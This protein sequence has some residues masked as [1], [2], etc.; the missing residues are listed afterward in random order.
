MQGTKGSQIITITDNDLSYF[1]FSSNTYSINE[2]QNAVITINRKSP[3]GTVDVAVKLAIAHVTTNIADVGSFTPTVNF[4]AGSI[5]QQFTVNIVDDIEDESDETFTIAISAVP[6]VYNI[7]PGGVGTTT[8]TIVDNDVNVSTAYINTT[9]MLDAPKD[10]LEHRNHFS[11]CTFLL[12]KMTA[13]L[14]IIK[15]LIQNAGPH[16]VGG[17]GGGSCPSETYKTSLFRSVQFKTVICFY[18]EKAHYCHDSI[19]CYPT[20][21]GQGMGLEHNNFV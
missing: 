11:L 19:Y 12:Q 16:T 18:L 17:G 4:P 13:L 14:F 21:L 20:H 1:E 7:V 2:D 15:I 10:D 3:V 9:E 6:N 5:S 8:V